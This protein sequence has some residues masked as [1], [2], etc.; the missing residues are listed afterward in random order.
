MS[1]ARK[2]FGLV[3]SGGLMGGLL[4]V[5]APPTALSAQAIDGC[6]CDDG[7]N[8]R[9]QCNWQQTECLVGSEVCNV[10]CQ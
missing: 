4:A 3:I 10:R 6:K 8:G 9:Y 7:G 5:I 2:V 1:V